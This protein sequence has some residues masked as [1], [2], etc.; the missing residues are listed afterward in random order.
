MAAWV[1]LAM[2]GAWDSC[3]IIL[4]LACQTMP[5][6]TNYFKLLSLP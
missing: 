2:L 6:S 4:N 3:L 1:R 5:A